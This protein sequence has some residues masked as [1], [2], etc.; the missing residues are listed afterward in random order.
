M[1]DNLTEHTQN[2][3][4]IIIEKYEN[5]LVPEIKVQEPQTNWT[6]KHYARTCCRLQQTEHLLLQEHY[7]LVV[8]V[9]VKQSRYRP[10]VAQRVPGS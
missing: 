4:R 1:K 10:G 7:H 2:F 9:K 6:D 8:K 3:L 5:I